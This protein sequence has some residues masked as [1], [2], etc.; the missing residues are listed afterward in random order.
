MNRPAQIK[1]VRACETKY[2]GPT[3]YRGSRVQATHLQLQRRYSAAHQ[4]CALALT[5]A[6]TCS[7]SIPP[8]TPSEIDHTTLKWRRAAPFTPNRRRP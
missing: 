4:R 7:R 2:F 8:T 3:D 6:G 1:Y 5:V